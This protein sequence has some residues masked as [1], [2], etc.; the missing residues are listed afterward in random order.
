MW[1]HLPAGPAQE[2]ESFFN[3]PGTARLQGIENKGIER[4]KVRR[5]K[6]L[7]ASPE[8]LPASGWLWPHTYEFYC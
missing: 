1:S 7:C 2:I 4:P 3:E 6:P 5:I 8:G